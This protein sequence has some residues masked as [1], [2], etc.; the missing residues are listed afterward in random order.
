MFIQRELDK[1]VVECSKSIELDA[2]YTKPLLRRAECYETLER[3]EE[4]L[5]DFKSLMSLEPSNYA[6]KRKCFVGIL[7]LIRK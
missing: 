7:R 3:L 2:G 6:H 1:C 4:S 5:G